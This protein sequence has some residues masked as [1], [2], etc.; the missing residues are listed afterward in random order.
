MTSAPTPRLA[1]T[2][3]LVRDA[4]GGLEVFMVQRHHQIDFATGGMVFPGGKI[5]TG[6][7]DPRLRERS[8]G[9]AALDADALTLRAAAIR[10]TFEE[11]GVLLARARGSAALVSAARLAEIEARWREKLNRDEAGLVDL[12]LAEDL[13]LALDR[14]VPFAHWVTPEMVPK[15]FDTH[16]FLA[17]APPDQAALHDGG[18]SVDSVW[19]TPQA[20]LAEAEAGRRT[21]IFPTLMNLNLLGLSTSVDEALARARRAPV[22]TVRP[23]L[24]RTPEGKP[25]LRIPPEAGYP[26]LPPAL[27]KLSLP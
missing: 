14:L 13:E 9:A 3:L 18:E 24:A 25:E 27:A 7:A 11:C 16:F 26:P 1:A 6:D 10:E 2:I 20:A 5:E 4:P 17:A 15:R 22:V 19:T 23:A 21:I 8:A 12:V